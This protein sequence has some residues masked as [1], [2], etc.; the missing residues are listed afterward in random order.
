MRAQSDKS[1]PQGPDGVRRHVP[2][3]ALLLWVA[4]SAAKSDP[5]PGTTLSLSASPDTVN[6][7][8]STDVAKNVVM[9]GKVS[10]DQTLVT[11]KLAIKRNQQT[12]TK[13]VPLAGS[14]FTHTLVPDVAGRYTVFATYDP[15]NGQ[16]DFLGISSKTRRFTAR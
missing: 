9:I 15:T 4:A 12:I 3:M 1:A 14:T 2:A 10:P 5:V 11:V 7:G 8:P 16:A 13:V 6:T